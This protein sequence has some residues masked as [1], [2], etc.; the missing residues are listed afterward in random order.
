MRIHKRL[1]D[2]VSPSEIVKQIVRPFQL[3]VSLIWLTCPA[4]ADLHVDRARCR[5]RGYHLLRQLSG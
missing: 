4:L 2:L 5:C 3:S 1:I